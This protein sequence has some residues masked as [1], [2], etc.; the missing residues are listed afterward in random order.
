MFLL[1]ILAHFR[2][3][4]SCLFI[5]FLGSYIWLLGAIIMMGGEVEGGSAE[6][7]SKKAPLLTD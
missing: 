5:C 6:S 4:G 2:N 3:D 1:S 7:Q